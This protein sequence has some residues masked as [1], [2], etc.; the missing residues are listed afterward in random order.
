MVASSTYVWRM[1]LEKKTLFPAATKIRATDDGIKGLEGQVAAY[2][3]LINT[4]REHY[5]Q[6]QNGT[7]QIMVQRRVNSDPRK[8]TAR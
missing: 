1:L 4:F 2:N 8:D 3:Q 7:V 6:H 5:E